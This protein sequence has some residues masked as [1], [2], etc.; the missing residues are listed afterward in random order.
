[1]FCGEG[2]GQL[3]SIFLFVSLQ[4]YLSYP[5]RA[6]RHRFAGFASPRF[7]SLIASQKH[8]HQMLRIYFLVLRRGNRSG[9]ICSPSLTNFHDPGSSVFPAE[10]T[11]CVR[12]PI[13]KTTIP[14]NYLDLN[15]LDFLK[16]TLSVT[17]LRQCEFY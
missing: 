7:D 15:L 17:F 4:K 14:S 6:R 13:L 11:C 8:S 12:Y 9:I 1:M 10:K 3:R 2:I 16:Q 5:T